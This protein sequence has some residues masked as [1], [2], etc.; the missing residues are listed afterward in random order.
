MR[1]LPGDE[2]AA[3][4]ENLIHQPRQAQAYACDLTV[5]GVSALTRSGALDFGGSEYTEAEHHLLEPVWEDDPRYGWWTLSPGAYVIRFNEHMAL[6][7][8]QIAFIQ[9]H[10]RLMQ[11]GGYHPSF[12]FRGVRD[13][14]EVILVVSA[15]DLRIKENARLSKLLV[16]QL[17]E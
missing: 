17:G 11:A 15:P 2:V 5:A 6:A 4:L 9:P 1:Y 14:L 10:Q 16:L 7:S 3:L 13:S 12:Y 8:D